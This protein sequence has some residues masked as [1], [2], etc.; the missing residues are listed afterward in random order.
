[1]IV[2]LE[3]FVFKILKP[4]YELI[5]LGISLH[6]GC[7]IASTIWLLRHLPLTVSGCRHTIS[8][9]FIIPVAPITIDYC[10]LLCIVQSQ[11]LIILQLS[12]DPYPINGVDDIPAGS[13]I[14]A[15]S[16]LLRYTEGCNLLV[17]IY[18]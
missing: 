5:Q 16:I 17:S 8:I 1:L 15:R 3:V 13:L 11:H 14:C 2:V 10:Y 4:L 18:K 6:V 9:P 12:L 7:C